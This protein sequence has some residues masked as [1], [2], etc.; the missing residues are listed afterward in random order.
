MLRFLVLYIFVHTLLSSSVGCGNF[1]AD[2]PVEGNA[3]SKM[4]YYR[5]K[6][7]V[8]SIRRSRSWVINSLTIGNLMN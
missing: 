3:P 6:A 4:P 2:S 1:G 8:N 5:L 7:F